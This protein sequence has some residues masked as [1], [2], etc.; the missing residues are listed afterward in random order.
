MICP[1]LG[2][3]LGKGKVALARLPS[4]MPVIIKPVLLALFAIAAVVAM[5]LAVVVGMPPAWRAM[6]LKIVDALAGR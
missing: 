5:M 2:K 1:A 6:R 4:L 3:K